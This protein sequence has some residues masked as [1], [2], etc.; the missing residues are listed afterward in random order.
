MWVVILQ[1]TH[2]VFLQGMYLVYTGHVFV[3]ILFIV[4]FFSNEEPIKS[5]RN[6]GTSHTAHSKQECVWHDKNTR[7]NDACV[8]DHMS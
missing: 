2:A 7:N 6:I 1:Q 5:E 8:C 4:L 3:P